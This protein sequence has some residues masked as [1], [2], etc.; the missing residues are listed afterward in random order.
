L[1]EESSC[2]SETATSS[3][4]TTG[5][6]LTCYSIE[7]QFLHR[8]ISHSSQYPTSTPAGVVLHQGPCILEQNAHISS[9]DPNSCN[10]TKTLRPAPDSRRQAVFKASK[11]V[12]LHSPVA[13]FQYC[14]CHCYV[15]YSKLD[16]S[17]FYFRTDI[18]R[19]EPC[20]FI[21]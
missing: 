7:F 4:T 14:P 11:K 2:S 21:R 18:S 16:P 19:T 8:H 20:S 13:K 12:L 15:S 9:R 10:R 17:R 1:T 5:L 6:R 3:F